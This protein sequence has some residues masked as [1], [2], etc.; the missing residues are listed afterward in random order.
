MI[1]CRKEDGIP[2][3]LVLSNGILVLNEGLYQQNNSTLSW[4]NL[5]NEEVISDFFLQKNNRQ[6]GDTGNDLEIYGA[7][8]YLVVNGSNT[9]EILEKSTG[10]SLKQINIMN[11]SIPK[12]PRSIAFYGSKA[13]ITCYDGFVDILDTA[14]LTITGRI[15]VGANPE[16]LTVSNGKLYVSNSGGLNYPNIDS[17]VSVI[18]L[19]NLQSLGK[20]TVGKNPGKI[21]T[22]S[23][24]DVYVITRGNYGSIP[25]RMVRI[26]S[27]SDTK[28]ETFSFDALGI[29]KM[30][31]Y[32]LITYYD[33]N[34]QQSAIRLFD[35]STELLLE[36]PFFH[37]DEVQTLYGI[38]YDP[39]RNKIYCLDAQGFTNSGYLR[40]YSA[41]GVFEASFHLG[42]NPN[43][44]I[45]YE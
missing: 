18:N 23:E 33:Y 25:A 1:S 12:S 21:I 22:D 9:L 37:A 16:D 45:F 14:T 7:K 13:F 8:I 43:N 19:S 26:N 36:D 41:S 31:D 24:G 6:L 27:I 28:E 42:L 34:S 44:V 2:V 15:P 3:P 4:I 29:E 10:K 30:N 5:D 17:T 39:Y 40:R 32:F 11:G 35:P 38:K 20:I